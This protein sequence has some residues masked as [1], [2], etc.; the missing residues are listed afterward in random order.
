M[1]RRQRDDG[2]A[3]TSAQTVT[4]ERGYSKPPSA[5]VARLIRL[6]N[7]ERL[8]EHGLPDLLG[9]MRR[10]FFPR[11]PSRPREA[12]I[13][14]CR[15]AIADFSAETRKF[16]GPPENLMAFLENWDQ[17]ELAGQILCDIAK[18]PSEARDD[19]TVLF[20]D[21]RRES[22]WKVPVYLGIDERGQGVLRVSP[23]L[24]A[25]ETVRLD[26]IRSC[27]VCTSIF[28]AS[29]SNSECCSLR[30]RKT[31]NQRTSRMQ[32]EEV[33]LRKDKHGERTKKTGR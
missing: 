16:L 9:V 4:Y 21:R 10:D 31:N 18:R 25:L 27:A 2:S 13:H 12:F 5:E 32:R 19:F 11:N 23:V 30:C 1:A 3:K 33:R 26:R 28:W 7:A 6:V 17:L 24:R 22:E 14:G 20:S 15:K 29:R 8:F